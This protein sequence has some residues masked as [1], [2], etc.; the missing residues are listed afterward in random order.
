MG[1][2]M[3]RR[4]ATALMGIAAAFG[5]FA[6][7]RRR[8]LPVIR[9]DGNPLG[10]PRDRVAEAGMESFPASDPPGWTLGERRDR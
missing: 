8:R 4:S 10:E 6:L 3:I 5:M 9:N 1:L 7:L 2:P